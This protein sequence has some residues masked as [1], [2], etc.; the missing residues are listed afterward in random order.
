M[1]TQT[2]RYLR[3]IVCLGAF[4]AVAA[5]M[6]PS[7]FALTFVN[8]P[9]GDASST[10]YIG[11]HPGSGNNYIYWKNNATG[12]CAFTYLG[13]GGLNDNYSISA[14][15]GDDTVL[16][17]QRSTTFCG[18]PTSPLNFNGHFMSIFGGDGNDHLIGGSGDVYLYGQGGSDVLE[19]SFGPVDL[20]G[21]DGND[22]LVEYAGGPGSNGIFE[23]SYGNDCLAINPT[24]T[25]WFMQCSNGTDQWYSPGTMPADCEVFSSSCC[26]GLIC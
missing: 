22:T 16:L 9:F 2:S 26:P 3:N 18:A 20:E 10:A 11:R 24:A 25:P 23:A 4:A 7:A 1:T 5:A 13:A 19:T 14:L 17:V 15:G 8:D 6:S 21:D 12:A